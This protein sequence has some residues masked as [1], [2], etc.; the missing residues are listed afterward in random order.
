MKRA[1]CNWMFGGGDFRRSCEA[2]ARHG[3]QGLE[4]AHSTLHEDPYAIGE[5]LLREVRRALRETG[6]AF[7]GLHA[8]L[9]A[10]AGLH[11]T[12]TD[13]A[14]RA[15]A[16]E[17]LRR[18]IDIAGALG[19]GT[20]VFGS[21]GPRRA[22]GITS[23]QAVAYL[24]GHLAELGPYAAERRSTILVEALSPDQTNVINTLEEAR[25]LIRAVDS[26]GV[27][28]IF[29]FHNTAAEQ[30]PWPALIGEYADII[31]HVHLNA[32]D[33]GLP[34]VK[35]PGF[36]AAFRALADREYAGWVSLEIFHQPE[37]PDAALAAARGFLAAMDARI[38]A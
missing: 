13:P 5:E 28:G 18:L 19:G 33:G 35:T 10:P 25:S 31:R 22:E 12:S 30:L 1:V 17:Q 23:A 2:A 26:P 38:R 27:S 8:L 11:I 6:L 16:R 29:D 7:V 14:V 4:L 24:R 32:M 34:S 9:Y 21:P 3:F 20:L 15:K 37:D 36:E